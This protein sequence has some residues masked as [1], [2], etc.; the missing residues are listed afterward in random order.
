MHKTQ[1]GHKCGYE[2]NPYSLSK[3][4]FYLQFRFVLFWTNWTGQ[5]TVPTTKVLHSINIILL[6]EEDLPLRLIL[7]L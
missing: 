2:P 4:T 3:K 7:T 1:L 6:A 5:D